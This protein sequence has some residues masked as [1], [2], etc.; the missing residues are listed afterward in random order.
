M[1]TQG[2]VMAYEC[3]GFLLLAHVGIGWM[4]VVNDRH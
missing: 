4:M 1:G 2:F 3:T